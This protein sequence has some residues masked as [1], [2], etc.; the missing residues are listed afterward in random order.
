MGCRWVELGGDLDN[1][2]QVISDWRKVIDEVRQVI[3]LSHSEGKSLRFV[4]S[5][6]TEKRCVRKPIALGSDAGAKGVRSG[7][8]ESVGSVLEIATLQ[9][10]R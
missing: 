1:F 2:V 3:V 7:K 8:S 9:Q 4:Y 10:R 6:F 5:F